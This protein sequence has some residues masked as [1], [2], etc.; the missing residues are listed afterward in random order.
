MSRCL[1][2]FLKK[3]TKYNE[4]EGENMYPGL[5]SSKLKRMIYFCEERSHEGAKSSL[6]SVPGQQQHQQVKT[7]NE[8]VLFARCECTN[9][10]VNCSSSLSFRSICK[11]CTTVRKI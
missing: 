1:L 10:C 2:N 7:A 3:A 8:N 9:D 4:V 5:I 6:F 11:N